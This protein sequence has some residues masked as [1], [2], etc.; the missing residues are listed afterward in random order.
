[1]WTGDHCNLGI[2]ASVCQRKNF[3]GLLLKIRITMGIEE[4]EEKRK[5]GLGW[6]N[7]WYV[8]FDRRKN[9]NI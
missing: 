7:D 4:E 1:M 2:S 3:S 6:C 5:L 8:K 9:W